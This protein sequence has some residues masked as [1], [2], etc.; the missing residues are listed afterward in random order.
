MRRALVVALVLSLAVHLAFTF[1][2]RELAGTP[3]RRAAHRH[4]HRNAAA[5]HAGR[6]AA[7]KPKPRR[8][9]AAPVP[10][11]TRAVDMPDEAPVADAPPESGGRGHGGGRDAP[12]R[13]DEARRSHSGRHGRPHRSCRRASISPTR[14]STA[15][16][17]S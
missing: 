1:L 12:R 9:R 8:K 11:P 16:A 14:C 6:A 5:A 3:G 2:A 13:G 4:A 10:A 15:R 7:A 17:A